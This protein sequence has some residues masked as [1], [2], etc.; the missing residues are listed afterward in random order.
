ML[1]ENHACNSRNLDPGTIYFEVDHLKNIYCDDIE[2]D[3]KSDDLT[4]ESIL[5][6]IRGRYSNYF[7][8]SKRIL[9]NEK[10]KIF[11]YMNGHA[12][13]NFFKI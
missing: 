5:N 13:E 11:I 10:S 3:Y 1:P 7:H 4:Y 8:H 2:I 6:I 12:G 9:T